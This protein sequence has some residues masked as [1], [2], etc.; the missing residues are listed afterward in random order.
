VQPLLDATTQKLYDVLSAL[1]AKKDAGKKKVAETYESASAAA[2]GSGDGTVGGQVDAA[3]EEALR[4]FHALAAKAGVHAAETRD[5]A[6]GYMRW[7]EGDA[8]AATELAKTK[9]ELAK[10][11]VSDAADAAGEKAGEAKEASVSLVEEGKQKVDES[12]EID[13]AAE[14][15]ERAEAAREKGVSYAGAAKGEAEEVVGQ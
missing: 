7:A 12:T 13:L 8:A 10:S 15:R 3:R 6:G 9:T 1:T 11:K 14:A 4:A 2:N 5:V